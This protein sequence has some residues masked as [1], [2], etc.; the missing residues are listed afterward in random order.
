MLKKVALGMVSV[1][2]AASLAACGTNNEGGASGGGSGSAPAKDDSGKTGGDKAVT[3][4]VIHWKNEAANKWFDKFNK[5][6]Q[7]KY[8]NIKVDY[9]TVPS[10]DFP[11]L[12]QT[13]I[14]ANDVDVITN[15]AALVGAPADWSKGAADPTWKQWIDAGLIADLSNQPFVKNYDPNAVKDA[16]TY[17]GKV[18]GITTGSVSF[19]GLFY[20]KDIFEKNGL[21]VPTTWDEFV[22]VCEALKSKGIAPIGFAG[23]DIWPFNLAVQG[24]QASIHKD[25]L[26]YIKGLWDGSAKFTDPAAIEILT[27]AQKMMSYAVNGFMGIDYGSL[28][29]LFAQGKVAMIADGTWDAPT[30]AAANPDLKFGYFPIPGSNDPAQN[31]ALAG[32]YD[33]TFMVAEKSKNK[34]AALKYLEFFS[35]PTNYAEYVNDVGFLPVQPNTDIKSPFIKELQPNLQGFKLSWDQLFINRNNAGEHVSGSSVHAEFLAPAG[36]IKTPQE[37]AVLSQKEW[38]AAK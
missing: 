3:L 11:Q 18:Y 36:P 14:Q 22:A 38:D 25:Q 32:K 6:F 10:T 20:N 16:D 30:I 8:P 5:K 1:V 27:K 17:N 23:K 13:R 29:G 26:A 31:K 33:M 4:K 7:E 2:M 37:L 35:D 21:K 9:A 12:Q 34:D 15:T 19:T 24:L 28:P